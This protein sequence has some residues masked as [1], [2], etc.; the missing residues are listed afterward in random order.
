MSLLNYWNYWQMEAE[1]ALQVL[2]HLSLLKLQKY[3]S[4]K[5]PDRRV[6]HQG[7]KPVVSLSQRASVLVPASSIS[8]SF[9]SLQ[10]TELLIAS[11]QDKICFLGFVDTTKA[12]NEAVRQLERSF[13]P[14]ILKPESSP[15]QLAFL[16]YLSEDK[17][18]HLPAFELIGTDFQLRVW[19]ELL[20]LEWGEFI[21][22]QELAG[23]V[24][25]ERGFQAIGTAVGRNPLAY[26]IPCHRVLQTSGGLGG[27]RWGLLRKLGFVLAELE[28]YE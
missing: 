10:N 6:L 13:S 7:Q 20:Q 8:Y 19:Y 16:A 17:S 14:S 22:Y 15:A 24:G 12:R 2:P 21:S 28:E 1:R 4:Q 23:R 25:I 11:H 27:F 5:V 3:A 9:Y 26:F 18:S